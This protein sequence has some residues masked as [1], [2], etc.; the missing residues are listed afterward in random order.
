M[1]TRTTS[2]AEHQADMQDYIQ[3]GETLALQLDNRG[4][5]RLTDKGDLHPDIVA[6]YRLHGCYVF[7]NVVDPQEISQLRAGIDHMLARAPVARGA[8]VDANAHG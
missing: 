8:K 2:A 4:P 1:N 7:E 5:L 3:Q 6:S